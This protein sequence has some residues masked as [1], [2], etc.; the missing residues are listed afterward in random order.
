MVTTT[1]GLPFAHHLEKSKLGAIFALTSWSQL[2]CYEVQ[3]FKENQEKPPG[4]DADFICHD[5]QTIGVAD[6]VGGWARKGVD[7]GE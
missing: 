5:A 1:T 3:H 6:G 4:E 7:T 2:N